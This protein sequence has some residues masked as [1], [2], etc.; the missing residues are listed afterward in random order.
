MPPLSLQEWW[1]N[2]TDTDIEA[3]IPKVAEYT[4]SDLKIMGDTLREWM[5]GGAE[6]PERWG[7]EMAIAF[8]LLGKIARA[9]AAYREGR[10]P[11]DDTIKDIRVYAVMMQRVRDVGGWPV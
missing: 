3:T 11:S 7:V 9:V 10:V 1:R 4:S 5:P 6:M 8:Y 2:L